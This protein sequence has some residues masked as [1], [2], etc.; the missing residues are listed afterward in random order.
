M[1]ASRPTTVVCAALFPFA[2]LALGNGSSGCKKDDTTPAPTATAPVPAPTPPPV[3]PVVPEEDA[4]SDAAA[5]A[6]AD[7][8][9]PVGSISSLTKCCNAIK[10]NAKSAPPDQ[11]LLYGAAIAACNSGAIP[12][13]FRNLPQCK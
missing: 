4:G 2:L 12:P 3:V 1:K 8:A 13:Q 6:D 7:A 9:K 11:Q 10:Q 5:D